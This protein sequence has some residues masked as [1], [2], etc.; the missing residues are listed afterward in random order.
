M[1]C[2]EG[3]PESGFLGSG[4]SKFYF[5]PFVYTNGKL[6]LKMNKSQAW[7]AFYIYK[8][9]KMNGHFFYEKNRNQFS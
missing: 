4:G 3:Q 2:L 9:L 8:V 1:G 5:F 7:Q 6:D